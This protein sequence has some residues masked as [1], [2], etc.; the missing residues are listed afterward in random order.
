MIPIFFDNDVTEGLY[1]KRIS[2]VDK[3]FYQSKK[4]RIIIER[5]IEHISEDIKEEGY[6]P[7][8]A[9]GYIQGDLVICEVKYLG[10]VQ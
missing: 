7:L 2:R 4:N 5:H 3:R 9:K 6:Q 8:E 10:V 1:T